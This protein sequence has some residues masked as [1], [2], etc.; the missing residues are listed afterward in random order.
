MLYCQE[1]YPPL[2]AL[3]KISYRDFQGFFY[4]PFPSYAQGVINVVNQHDLQWNSD[5]AT[6]PLD[7]TVAQNWTTDQTLRQNSNG[8]VFS[9]PGKNKLLLFCLLVCFNSLDKVGEYLPV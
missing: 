9:L 5:T 7:K 8:V 3:R 1:F 2:L 6:F 4:F